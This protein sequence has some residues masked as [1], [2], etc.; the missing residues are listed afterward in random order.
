MF[1]R[2]LRWP[3]PHV[4]PAHMPTQMKMSFVTKQNEAKIT[5]V[6]LNSFT[7]GLTKFAPFFLIGIS[8]FLENLH[9]IWKQL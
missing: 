3:K 7:D 2:L 5:W 6:V 8:L 4:L 9:F 1:M